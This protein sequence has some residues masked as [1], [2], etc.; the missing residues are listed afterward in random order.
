MTTERYQEKPMAGNQVEF[1]EN[2]EE[3]PL[4]AKQVAQD[5]EWA[6]KPTFPVY[7]HGRIRKDLYSTLFQHSVAVVGEDLAGRKTMD[8]QFPQ[9]AP[10]EDAADLLRVQR[11]GQKIQ[12]RWL[13]G[14]IRS[15][16]LNEGEA[17]RIREEQGAHLRFQPGRRTPSPASKTNMIGIDATPIALASSAAFLRNRWAK[18]TVILVGATAMVLETACT[19]PASSTTNEGGGKTSVP[20]TGTSTPEVPVSPTA[21]VNIKITPEA[22]P[23]SVDPKEIDLKVGSPLPDFIPGDNSI[24][25]A[26][27]ESTAITSGNEQQILVYLQQRGLVKVVDGTAL[28]YQGKDDKAYLPVIP[29]ITDPTTGKV[30]AP[31]GNADKNG[32]ITY[33]SEDGSVTQYSTNAVDCTSDF[34]CLQVVSFNP[35]DAG[36][37]YNLKIDVKTGKIVGYMP[38][39]HADKSAVAFSTPE[40]DKWGTPMTGQAALGEVPSVM[41]LSYTPG[42]ESTPGTFKFV[43]GTDTV[44]ATDKQIAWQADFGLR[45][46]DDSGNIYV[47]NGS[48][49]EW[50]K[51]STY[52]SADV[53]D[54]AQIFTAGDKNFIE[55]KGRD[56]FISKVAT[57]TDGKTLITLAD[58]TQLKW[59][60]G[61]WGPASQ[62]AIITQ[63]NFMESYRNKT[64]FIDLEND[65]FSG[66][67]LTWRRT[68][69]KPFDPNTTKLLPVFFYPK[70]DG[71]TI[72]YPP[73]TAPNFNVLPPPMRKDVTFA[74]ITFQGHNYLFLTP[75]YID[76]KVKNGQSIVVQVALPLFNDTHDFSDEEV[77]NLINTL[78]KMKIIPLLTGD[79]SPF[80]KNKDPLIDLVW[81]NKPDIQTR[82]QNFA[83]KQEYGDLSDPGI[84]V[85]TKVTVNQDGSVDPWS[86]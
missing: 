15:G 80:S 39:I 29:K 56:T 8:I 75:E 24:N 37:T 44:T 65:V 62:F 81:K 34:V 76:P 32:I 21:V 28:S 71:G 19:V 78:G 83:G 13:N 61:E 74:C 3:D 57:D 40:A 25:P 63:E 53:K 35:E 41:G 47:W 45:V 26:P 7:D 52:S 68:L 11:I 2:F 55:Y 82:F 72:T 60:S 85:L 27:N 14:A 23:T 38:A 6:K 49:N 43:S 42:T 69:S 73:E 86:Q 54:G 17:D 16:L 64:C 67:Y 84:I 12:E 18:A 59:K 79:V 48:K 36:V 10:I 30:L 51:A 33:K 66:K 50:V 20:K 9:L 1:N 4:R 5:V 31:T 77:Q 22:P 70:L 58:G 46:I